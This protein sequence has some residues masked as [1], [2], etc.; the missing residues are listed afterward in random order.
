MPNRD[1]AH[2]RTLLAPTSVVAGT[3]HAGAQCPLR[4]RVT[5]APLKEQTA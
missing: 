1:H 3:R 5:V 2:D 4:L